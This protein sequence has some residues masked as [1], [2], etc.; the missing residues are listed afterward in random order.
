MKSETLNFTVTTV[1][2]CSTDININSV[3]AEVRCLKAT[4]FLKSLCYFFK[5]G[6]SFFYGK[7]KEKVVITSL[8]TMVNNYFFVGRRNRQALKKFF[9]YFVLSV[10]ELFVNIFCMCLW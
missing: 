4:V 8:I 7:M 1:Q 10:A 2:I 5:C 9:K 6:F 3:Q